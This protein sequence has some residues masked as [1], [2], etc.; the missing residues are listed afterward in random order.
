MGGALPLGAVEDPHWSRYI[1]KGTAACGSAHGTLEMSKKEGAAKRNCCVLTLTCNN[2]LRG[3]SGT[4]GGNKQRRGVWSEE[5]TERNSD[6]PKES[7]VISPTLINSSYNSD[8][9]C[10]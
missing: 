6:V 2:L 8:H 3:L 9:A 7:E 10:F 1:P 4:C 5:V